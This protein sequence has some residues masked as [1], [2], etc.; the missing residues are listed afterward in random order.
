MRIIVFAGI[1][2]LF[3]VLAIKGHSLS[4]VFSLLGEA[5]PYLLVAAVAMAIVS[6][7]VRGWRWTLLLGSGGY[8][9]RKAVA[10]YAVMGGYLANMALPRAGEAMRCVV[11]SRKEKIPLGLVAGTVVME[12]AVDFVV[13]IG[14]TVVTLVMQADNLGKFF[15]DILA[16]RLAHA[17]RGWAVVLVGIGVVI[18]L[19]VITAL[20][21]MKRGGF[22]VLRV[23]VVLRNFLNELKS[24]IVAVFRLKPS[25]QVLFYGQTAIIWV[26]YY[27][28]TWAPIVA[29]AQMRKITAEQVLGFFVYGSWGIVAPVQGGFGTYHWLAKQALV[30]YGY[31]PLLAIQTATVVHTV[32]SLGIIF[33][34]VLSF[35]GLSL[36][37]DVS[38][39]R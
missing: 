15:M 2:V 12:R 34:G 36:S 37:R 27:L 30:L 11:V 16:G 17:N 9:M 20:L 28:M 8:R 33:V 3:F 21:L 22:R 39:H 6:H 5:D 19:A 24:G 26:L 31:D 25:E 4:E 1:G 7:W 18:L 23:L 29:I 14:I 32:H 35:L 13:L 38:N 10:F